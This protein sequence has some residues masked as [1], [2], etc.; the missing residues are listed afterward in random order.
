MR[1]QYRRRAV[2]LSQYRD[3]LHS[4]ADA[5]A[6]DAPKRYGAAGR[7]TRGYA[8]GPETFP[9]GT[10]TVT[11]AIRGPTY[12]HGVADHAR[13]NRSTWRRSMPRCGIPRC[14]KLLGRACDL[15]TALSL[16]DTRLMMAS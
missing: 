10:V 3:A 8:G 6:R 15:T 9:Y 13:P 7:S 5:C 4:V 11:I 1:R 2:P 16:P 12:G 14:S